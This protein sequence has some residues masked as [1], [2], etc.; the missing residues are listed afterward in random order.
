MTAT[1]RSLTNVRREEVAPVLA[2]GFFFFCVLTALM[3]LRPARDALGM[4]R[5]MDAIRWLFVGTAI[6]TLLVNPVFGLLVSRFRRLFFITATYLFFAASL[7][8]FYGLLMFAPQAVGVTSGQVFYVWF[9]VFNLFVTMVF[10][11]LMVDRFSLEQSKR[12]FGVIAVGGTAGAIFGPW[13]TSQLAQPLGTANLLLVSVA[14]LGLAVAAAWLVAWLQP[15]RAPPVADADPEA[16][17]A[18]DEHAVIGGSAWEGFRATLRS[19]Y[20]LGIAAFVLILAIMATLLYF[21]RLQM[22]AALGDDLDLRT[23]VFA[24]IDFI[25]QVTTLLLQLIVA[26]HLMKRVGVHIALALLPVTVAL[27]FIGLAMV[28]SLVALIVFEAAFR[29]VQRAIMR[30]ARETLYT[31][32]SRE[33][34]YKAKAFIDT[35]VY[36]GGD[37]VGAWTEGLLGRLGMALAGLAT[38]ALPLAVVWAGLG[39]WLGRTQQA[40]G[41]SAVAK[42]GQGRPTLPIA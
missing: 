19:P 29:A 23:A 37:V 35:F 10:W 14:F 42:A 8:V 40:A 32:V 6:V 2:S 38:V 4:Q 21:T 9:S 25:T 31:V 12:L 26:G 41:G 13:L 16:P 15:E 33:D 5:G 22:V 7:L 30:P 1:L 36:R 24:R 20:L 3:V 27:G 28:G 11:A 34:K 17:P 39:L 18:V